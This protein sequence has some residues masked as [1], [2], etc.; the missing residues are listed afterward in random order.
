MAASAAVP[1]KF[2][3]A[4]AAILKDESADG[5]SPNFIFFDDNDP[6]RLGV[7]QIPRVVL[8]LKIF[9]VGGLTRYRYGGGNRIERLVANRSHGLSQMVSCNRYERPSGG[10]QQAKKAVCPKKP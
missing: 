9:A 2:L 7:G 5:M 6:E 10:N 3:D 1:Q 8:N 4:K